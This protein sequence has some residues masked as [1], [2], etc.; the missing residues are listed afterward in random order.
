ML[1]AHDDNRIRNSH[2]GMKSIAPAAA[3]TNKHRPDF[4][5]KTKSHALSWISAS[6]PSPEG[7]GATGCLMPLLILLLLLPVVLLAL[8]PFMLIQRYRVGTARRLARPW[9]ATFAVVMMCLSTVFFLIGSAFTT[10]WVRD[11]FSGAAAGVAIGSLLGVVGLVLTRWEPTPHTLHYTPN[12]WLVLFITFIVSARMLYG[13]YRSFLVAQAG[14]DRNVGDHGIRHSR[15]AGRRRN[16]DW[17]L[18][19]VWRG[20]TVAHQE[21]STPGASRDVRRRTTF[22]KNSERRLGLQMIKRRELRFE[23][24]TPWRRWSSGNPAH[25]SAWRCNHHTRRLESAL[26][27]PSSPRR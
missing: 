20:V 19:G 17:L 9:M 12:R 8:T 15:I 2:E 4:G 14:V 27:R 5:Q 3:A 10:I 16:R 7:Y 18:P 13:L 24:R 22:A 11:A 26:R 23:W 21:V 25:R 6:P 1:G